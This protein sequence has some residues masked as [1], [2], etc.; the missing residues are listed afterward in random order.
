MNDKEFEDKS[1]CRKLEDV[2]KSITV[3]SKIK[4][5]REDDI[6]VDQQ[7]AAL[8]EEPHGLSATKKQIKK[9]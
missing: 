1:Q 6:F 9:R 2:F 8:P 3:E 5:E 7:D 4:V